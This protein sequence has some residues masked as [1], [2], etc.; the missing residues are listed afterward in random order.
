[1]SK[2]VY[3]KYPNENVLFKLTLGKEHDLTKLSPNELKDKSYF[4]FTLI[5]LH[6]KS[7][8]AIAIRLFYI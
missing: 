4:T 5:T 3:L 1:M 6:K 8:T 7:L 2:T